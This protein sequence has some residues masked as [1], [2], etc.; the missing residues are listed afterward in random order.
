MQSADPRP[1]E[2]QTLEAL[3]ALRVLDSPPEAEFDALARAA[4]LA[5]GTPIALISLVDADRQWFK[6]NIGLPGV[7]ETARSV[8]FCAHAVLGDELFEV[9][10]AEQD[11]RFADNPLV[12]GEPGVRFYAGAPV[13]LSSG[14]RV[15][16]LCIIDRQP[17]RLTD[18][19]REILRALAS[20]AAQAL[21]GRHA[22]QLLRKSEDFLDRTG[23]VAGVGG[24]EVDIA[25]GEITWSA[26]TRRIHRVAS[27][28]KP[29][30]SEAINF[31]AP[32]AR[33]VIQ[34][35]VE[36]GIAAGEA[37]DLELPL[38][39]ADGQRIWARAVGAVE[40]QDGK[41][42]RLVGAFQDITERK[43]LELKL[44]TAMAEVQDLYD[45]APSGYHSLDATG[46][47]LHI[48]ATAASWLGC[49][50]EDLIGKR[51]MVEF[52]TPEGQEQFRQNFAKLMTS[53]RVEG[54]EFDLAPAAG[55]GRR[56][57]V[58]ATAMKDAAGSFL[59]S[60][61][62]MFDITE[63]HRTRVQL[64]QLSREQQ[65]MLDNDL[66]GIV[67][68]RDRR[69]IWANGGMGRLFGYSEA[70]WQDM[71]VRCLYLD[72]ETYERIG[73]DAYAAMRDAG[74]Y[75][76]QVQMRRKDGSPIWID[77]SGATLSVERGEVML[78]LVDVTSL[79]D[80]EEARIKLIELESQNAQLQETGRLKDQFVSN[81]SHELR[82]PLNAVIGYAHLLQS[83]TIKP[84]SP[85]YVPY[86]TQIGA[87]GKHLL[88]LIDSMLDF[89]KTQSGRMEFRPE[90]TFVAH[91]IND[92]ID[93][94]QDTCERKRVVATSVVSSDLIEA[95]VDP[96]RLRQ[97][98][99]SLLSNA[100][101]FSNEY[102]R[103]DV[104]ARLEGES[105]F[106][107]EV[108]D[109]GIGI[110]E[111]DLPRLFNQ[112]HQLSSGNTKTHEGTGLGLAL[113]RRMIEAQGGSV[114]VQSRI[115][116]GSTFHI[117]LPLRAH[118]RA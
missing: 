44:A 59:M 56:V 31:Y 19:Q 6:A 96:A 84:G 94:L 81:M 21:E 115:G 87:S 30:M 54:L 9:P 16:T 45:N 102:G 53:G 66:V 2:A 78:L 74:R 95:E 73:R 80:A 113:V 28:F 33:P 85:K 64:Q 22:S 7:T 8:A 83:G 29:V 46:T 91:V 3:N 42:K 36:R 26:E 43:N 34:A 89:A 72:D 12:A 103:I 90:R 39:C 61:T 5:C 51:R 106:R 57:S 68:L 40:F 69:V 10:D 62:V 79:K 27:D 71:P 109:H 38:I 11:A 93:M 50:R 20:V 48:N 104:R 86:L 108:E 15:G 105:H 77:V 13:Q 37:W 100:V 99:L 82:T 70:E 92:V 52:F 114:G 60:R 76:E 117:T 58:T 4:S 97:V 118:S 63:L 17:R 47:F 55:P 18:T 35:A 14:H 24:W 75:R 23:R 1:D 88:Q 101:K 32:E 111:A 116:E 98:L 67:R 110:S 65:A 25:T 49:R 107:V 112:F 41:P